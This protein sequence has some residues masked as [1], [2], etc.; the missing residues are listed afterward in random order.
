MRQTGRVVK[1]DIVWI[2]LW[3]QCG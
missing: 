1:V 3:T 2:F